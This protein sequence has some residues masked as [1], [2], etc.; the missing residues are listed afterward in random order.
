MLNLESKHN[1]PLATTKYAQ[2]DPSAVSSELGRTA[3]RLHT[4]KI[5]RRDFD[6]PTFT[7]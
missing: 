4:N 5:A 2:L 6:G 1:R 3:P 7:L